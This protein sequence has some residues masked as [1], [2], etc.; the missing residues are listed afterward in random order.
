MLS[1]AEI[2]E[3]RAEAEI[4]ADRCVTWYCANPEGVVALIDRIETLEG[5]LEKAH[6]SLIPMIRAAQYG[7][8]SCPDVTLYDVT[9]AK[10]VLED[11][12][13]ALPSKE[14]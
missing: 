9:E 11:V 3:L 13:A 10:A 7:L 1:K 4:A 6:D 14:D 5:A 2:A 8:R 12:K